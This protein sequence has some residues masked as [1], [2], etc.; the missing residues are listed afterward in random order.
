MKTLYLDCNMGAAGDMIAASLLELL[1]DKEA[2][3]EQMNGLGI[4]H[5]KM[6]KFWVL[7]CVFFVVFVYFKE[8]S[9]MK[10]KNTLI[11]TNR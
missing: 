8:V 11:K 5:V 7:I 1:P 9:L 2:F 6:E 4:P 3:L 10:F